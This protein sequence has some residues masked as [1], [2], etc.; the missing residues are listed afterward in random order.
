MIRRRSR[1]I[2][3]TIGFVLILVALFI[4]MLGHH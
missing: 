2:R 3:D 1:L 4:A